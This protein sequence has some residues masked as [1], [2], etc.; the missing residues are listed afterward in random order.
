[1]SEIQR[2]VDQLQRAFEGNAWHGPSVKEVLAGV[3]AHRAAAKPMAAAHGIW[4][5]VHHIAAWEAI[6]R[7]RIEGEVIVDVAD[8]EDWPRVGDTSEA[9]WR[10]S[11]D[12]LERGHELLRDAIVGMKESR[13]EETVPGKDHSFYVLVHGV[14]Q[15]DLYHAGQIALLKRAYF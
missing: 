3:T 2:I 11:L 5:L 9:A 14:V 7:R 15:H 6:V 10:V 1:M 8:D 13:L 12:E 4:E